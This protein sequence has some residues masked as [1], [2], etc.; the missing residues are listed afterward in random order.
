DGVLNLRSKADG[1]ARRI[2]TARVT[3]A[4]AEAEALRAS[5]AAD[6]PVRLEC[7]MRRSSGL[8][9]SLSTDELLAVPVNR[10]FVRPAFLL[11]DRSLTMAAIELDRDLTMAVSLGHIGSLLNDNLLLRRRRQR[12]QKFALTDPL[13]H[14]YNR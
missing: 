2:V 4:P 7:P 3:A 13:T 12:A 9:A 1:S 5:L 8:L 14:L 10:D 6:Q 11:L